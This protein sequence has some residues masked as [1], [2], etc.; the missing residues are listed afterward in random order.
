MVM[1]SDD[2]E[3]KPPGAF[4]LI[5]ALVAISMTAVAGS[6]LLLGVASSLQHTDDAMRRT[7]ALGLAQQLM[8]EVASAPSIESIDQYDGSFSEPPA[9]PWGVSLGTEDGK[10]GQRHASFQ[11]PA[12]LLN[13]FGREVRVSRVAASDLTAP[14]PAGA[15]SDYRLVEV[16]VT[17]RAPN[18]SAQELARVQRIVAYV[19]PYEPPD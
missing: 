14:L 12:G 2:R 18:T 7:I 15:E 13:Q 19:P 6:V 4:T 11:A 10:G 16:R 17:Y 3:S 1:P 5:E 9:D 8:D